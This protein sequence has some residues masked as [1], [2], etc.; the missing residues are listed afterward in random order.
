TGST[1]S[2]APALTWRWAMIVSRKFVL[3]RSLAQFARATSALWSV[4]LQADRC[5]NEVRPAK[6]ASQG[7]RSPWMAQMLPCGLSLDAEGPGGT[8]AS[9]PV[10]AGR[11]A[12]RHRTRR[13]SER[14]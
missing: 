9:P 13:H 5:V 4:R 12:A 7:L 10:I 1:L 8:G 2:S 14:A 6:G 3:G 11:R